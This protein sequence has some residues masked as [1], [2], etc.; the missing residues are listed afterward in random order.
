MPH[1]P[2]FD[3]TLFFFLPLL[4]IDTLTYAKRQCLS[5]YMLEGAC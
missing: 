3:H 4:A 1:Q 2:C 5:A